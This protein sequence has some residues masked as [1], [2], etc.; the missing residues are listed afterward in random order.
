MSIAAVAIEIKPVHFVG[1]D[2][3]RRIP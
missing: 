2:A 1:F 3:D